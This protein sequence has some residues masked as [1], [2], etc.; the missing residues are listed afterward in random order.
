MITEKNLNNIVTRKEREEFLLGNTEHNISDSD[1]T[2]L[3]KLG[4]I[5][6]QYTADRVLQNIT[7]SVKYNDTPEYDIQ[8]NSNFYEVKS[9]YRSN[10][11]NNVFIAYKHTDN[12]PASLLSGEDSIFWIHYFMFCSK[13]FMLLTNKAT[14]RHTVQMYGTQTFSNKHNIIGYQ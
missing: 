11:T 13:W 8:I 14:L 10:I 1:F 9:D 4:H 2:N 3:N 5:W 7:G 12:S 6:E